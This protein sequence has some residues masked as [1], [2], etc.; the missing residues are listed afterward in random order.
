MRNNKDRREAKRISYVCEVECDGAGLRR[1]A[2]R[3]NDLS[4]T[5]AFIDSMTCYSAG[6][7]IR[8]RFRI[9][10]VLIETKAEVRYSMPRM[11]MG[12]RFLDLKPIHIA[13]LESLIEGKPMVPPPTTPDQ[14]DESER[15][16]DGWSTPDMLLGN[17]AVVSMFD[18]IQLIENNRLGGALGVMSPAASGEIHFNDGHIVGANSGLKAGVEALK[19]FLDVTTGSFE[20]KRSPTQYPRT[21]DAQSNMSLMLDLL[22]VKDEEDALGSGK[23]GGPEIESVY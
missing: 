19:S 8:L 20:F 16:A 22:R 12:V 3:I 21:I 7:T 17:F 9:N 10:D 6:T 18:V 2:T 13:A 1:L 23:E 11:G 14:Q 4:M 15:E 5:G